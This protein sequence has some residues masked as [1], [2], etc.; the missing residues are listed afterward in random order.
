MVYCYFVFFES[1]FLVT[2]FFLGF[3]RLRI[4]LTIIATTASNN[5]TPDTGRIMGFSLSRKT[6]RS[7]NSSLEKK[8][9]DTGDHFLVR[10]E[11]TATEMGRLVSNANE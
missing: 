3:S 1:F 11:P 2:V 10:G 7:T 8:I 5:R 4:A 9:E 6:A